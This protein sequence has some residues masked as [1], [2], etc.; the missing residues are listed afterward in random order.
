MTIQELKSQIESRNVTDDLIIFK[1]T[2]SGFVS[3][4][5]VKAIAEIKGVPIEYMESPLEM[6]TDLGSILKSGNYQ[7]IY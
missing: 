3:N 1:D 7:I 6:A 4:Q 5:Y 2:E